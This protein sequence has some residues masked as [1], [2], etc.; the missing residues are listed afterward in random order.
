[1]SRP[2]AALG[3]MPYYDIRIPDPVIVPDAG[4]VP[5][6]G[7]RFHCAAVEPHSLVLALM[8]ILP[9]M[10]R[11]RL[12]RFALPL[13]ARSSPLGCDRLGQSYMSCCHVELVPHYVSTDKE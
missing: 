8:P 1:M 6:F 3:K 2:T 9:A 7:M 13:A 11:T 10:R 12:A 4:E 5:A